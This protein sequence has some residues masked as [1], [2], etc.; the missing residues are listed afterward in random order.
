LKNGVGLAL[1]L[2]PPPLLCATLANSEQLLNEADVFTFPPV[3]VIFSGTV[4]QYVALNDADRCTG[5]TVPTRPTMLIGGVTVDGVLA[6]RLGDDD[7]VEDEINL[8]EEVA[9]VEEL[10]EKLFIFC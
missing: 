2:P 1:P 9:E 8:G 7:E 3:P 4:V 6:S 10:N 5:L